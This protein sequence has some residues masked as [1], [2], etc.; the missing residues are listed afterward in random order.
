M[1]Y[2][3]LLGTLA[4]ALTPAV[5]I[6]Q[7]TVVS[8]RVTA[9][10]RGALSDVSVS[11]PEL[12]V[13]AVTRDDGR[14]TI[15]I[16]GARVTG[17]TV[18][19]TARRIG[20]RSQSAR[21]ALT[22]GTVSQD[23]ALPPN[24]LQLGEVVVTG[25]GTTSTVERLGSVRNVVS[26][27][28]IQKANEPNLVQALAGKAPNVQVS[29]TAGDPG[30][31]SRIQIRGLRTLNGNVE[32]LFIID[33]VP[34]TN[35]TFSSTNFNPIDAGGTGVGGQDVGGEFEGTSAPNRMVD[36]N[37]DD[38]E[39]VE[40]LKGAAAA[41]I[42]GARAANGVILITTKHGRGGATRYQLRSSYSSDEVTRDYPLQSTWSL[43]RFN[44]SALPCEDIG[45]S[46]CT[47]SWG[48]KLAA[49]TPVYDHATEA[50][51]NGHIADNTITVSGGSE[52]TT[53]FLSGG[54]MR[55]Q[56]V[57]VGPNNYFNRSTVRLNATHRLTEGL[58]LGGNFSYADTRGHFTQRGNNVNGLLLGLLRTPPEFN[59]TV[60][61]DPTSGLHRSY[62]M[63]NPDATTAAQSRGFN[64]PF[65][66]LYDELNQQQAARSF[67]N[68]TADY[69]AAE[70]LKF[71]YSLGA[72]YTNDERL[73]GCPAECSD[74]AA[75][76]R[77]TEGK[78]INYQIDHSLTATATHKFSD[79]VGVNLTLGQ[80]LNAR[81]FRTFSVVGRTL[82]APTPFSVLNTLSRDPPSDY[83]TQVHNASVFGQLQLDLINQV[84]LTGALRDD[85]STTFGKSNRC[86]VFPKASAAW[87]FTNTYQPP[88][89]TF[90]KLRFSYGEAG[91]EPQ[92]YLSSVTFSGTNLVGGIAQG[93]G[94]TPTQS[95]R[96][97]LFFTFTKPATSL[98]P[99]RTREAEAGF[100]IG[101]LGEKADLSATWYS[102]KTSDVILVT[103]I[104]PSSGYSSEAKN[105]GKLRNSGTELQLNL[106]PLTR[107]NYA[108]DLGIGWANNHSRVDTLIGAQFLYI[109]GAFTGNVFQ[110][111][112][113][114]GAI[115]GEGWVRCGISDDDA[116]P[117]ISLAT[118]CA[119][120]P[121][122]AL[123]ID[124]GTNCYDNGMPCEDTKLRILGDPNPKWTGNVHSTFRF[125]KFALSGLV[126]I[127][128]GGIMWNGTRGALWSY[129]THKDTEGRA[130][131]TGPT[132]A[133][134]TGNVHAFGD[135]NWFPG[136]VVGP[137]AGAQI[138]I[139]ENWYR[140]SN[141]AA[142]PF[143]GIDEPCM[144]DGG[145]VKLRE[146]SI[147]YSFTQAWVSRS[148]GMSSLDVRVSGRN[149]KTWTKYT[150]LDPETTTGQTYDRVGGSDYFN[151][152]LT[153]SVVVTLTLNR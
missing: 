124:D 94:F 55:N 99:E 18:T 88:G 13:G 17:Q 114:I 87:T 77:I 24:P 60:F 34:V 2:R 121:K 101:F 15:T 33:G 53:F 7:A 112:S 89:F 83:Q 136:P 127:K 146:V 49:G 35:Y 78:V 108:W 72:D 70:W 32:P 46:S 38:I 95:G 31:N 67:G 43:G 57:F 152:P 90:G 147:A 10:N 96:G 64:N 21:I 27:D 144:E 42:Y 120:K 23:I 106:R 92:P 86:A 82:I 61:L 29:Q 113:P 41:A 58:Q 56:G 20:Y 26:P 118:Y 19:I 50:F 123:Y 81:N 3:F 122:G 135:A 85:C 76:G 151:L 11:I 12:G 63:Q 145:Y 4:L 110:I 129:G 66:T 39:N 73:E 126:D 30:A 84:Y 142:C 22:P 97:G 37:S 5:A 139:G 137:G 133:D 71:N 105:A 44:V 125:G 47:R 79:A 111:G 130:T 115:R 103:P 8:G 134:C 52:R 138:P 128:K 98:K 91:N 68:I 59:N 9:E 6:A 45:K 132:N 119:G 54:S 148:L 40:I 65:Y 74:V 93:T 109:P 107:S 149:L 117:G 153:R 104:P 116:V 16:P 143:T 48:P 141:L 62:R 150:G 75:G 80:N 51:R 102:S 25:A 140:N 1:Q 131:C 14:Y 36:I 28:L 100:D 69:Q